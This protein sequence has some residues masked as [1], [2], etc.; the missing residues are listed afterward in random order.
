ML[1]PFSRMELYFSRVIINIIKNL[2]SYLLSRLAPTF[3][4]LLTRTC[5][6]DSQSFRPESYQLSVAV[7]CVLLLMACFTLAVIV[8]AFVRVLASSNNQMIGT[9]P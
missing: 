8:F 9:L 1:E 3:V 6:C 4:T 5:V 7:H 2:F